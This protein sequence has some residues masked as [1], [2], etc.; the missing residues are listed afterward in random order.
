MHDM[1]LQT[2][3][4]TAGFVGLLKTVPCHHVGV[5]VFHVYHIYIIY[6]F[7]FFIFKNK[8]TIKPYPPSPNNNKTAGVVD[9]QYHKGKK[10]MKERNVK[11]TLPW[12]CFQ[13]TKDDLSTTEQVPEPGT[14]RG[15]GTLSAGPLAE[16]A[17]AA[18]QF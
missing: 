15:Q 12:R 14:Q 9:S 8:Q 10:K 11:A 17:Q 18:G 16:I 13:M 5:G 3:M 4:F 1:N 6:N 2:A 7:L